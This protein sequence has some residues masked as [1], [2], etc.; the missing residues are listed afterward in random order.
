MNFSI[1]DF[2]FLISFNMIGTLAVG[3]ISLYIRLY[4]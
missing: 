3:L 4:I 1:D 2:G